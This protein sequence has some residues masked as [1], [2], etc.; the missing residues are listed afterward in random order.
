MHCEA[1]NPQL[2]AFAAGE[3][4]DNERA[5]IETHL[6][7]CA[8]CQEDYAA[9]SAWHNMA[10]NWHDG[11]APAWQIPQLDRP[12]YVQQFADSFRQ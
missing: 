12:S 10:Q 2:V 4:A 9:I 1:A 11:V 3:T 6:N 7:D 8:T 5:L